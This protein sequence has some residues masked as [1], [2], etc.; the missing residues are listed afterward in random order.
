MTRINAS[1]SGAMLLAA[2]L[3]CSSAALLAASDFQSLGPS[4]ALGRS[5]CPQSSMP[6]PEAPALKAFLGGAPA[7]TQLAAAQ[8]PLHLK[9][10]V[11]RVQF[12]PDE[13]PQTTG[14]GTW[15]DIPFFTFDGTHSGTIVEDH[16]I[17]SRAKIYVQR[18]L[19]WASQYYQAVSR[20][21]VVLEVPD[22]LEDISAIYTLD[23]EM[24]E[25]GKDD[26]YSL[27]T[28]QLAVDAVKAADAEMDFSKYDMIM[29]FSAGCGQHTDFVPDSPDDI[30]P[31]SINRVLL[32]EILED[33]DPD[34]Q[35]IA[36]NDRKPD[37]SPFYVQFIQIFP[38]TAV[39][40]WDKEGNSQGALQGLLGVIVHEIGHYFGLPD[41]YDTMVGTRPTVG[42]YSLMATGFFNTVS[43]IPSH[44]DAWCKVFMGWEEPVTVNGSWNDIRIK[45]TELWG[46]GVRV[47]KVPISS[48][49]Y[50][51][52]E[53]RLRDE[54]FN[55]S[56]DF[57]ERGGNNFFP[58]VL[59]DDYQMDDGRYA[60]FDWSIPNTLGPNLPAMSSADS[61]RLGSGILIWHIDE[62]VLRRNFRDDLTLNF[63]NTEPQHL[64]IG[65]VEADGLN[66]MLE[67]FPAALD[68][69]FGSPFDVFG[70]AVPGVKNIDNDNL[71][72]DFGP[73]TNP[74]TVSHTGLPSNI[75]ISGFRSV[76][77]QPDAPVVDS[78]VALDVQ[79][80]AVT[81]GRHIPHTLSGWPR[82]LERLTA[83]S[84]PLVIDVDPR[85][86]GVDAV[87]VTDDGRVY[88]A[89][90]AGGG[91]FAAAA[92]DSVQG[93]PAAG[94]IDGDGS[95]DVVV[96]TSHGSVFAWRLASD[97]SMTLLPGW[98]VRLPGRISATPVLA[99]M[100]GNGA[101]EVLL[102]N[103]NGAAGSQLFVLT[104]DGGHLNG[105]PVIIED[106]AA[107][108]VAVLQDATLAPSAV[109]VGTLEGKLLAFDSQGREKYEASLGSPVI[110]AP[111][112]GRMGL[113]GSSEEQRVCVFTK[114]GK[115]WSLSAQT[116]EA[117]D[118]WPVITGGTCLSGGALGDVD[119]DGLNELV[120]PVDLTDSPERE[121][122]EL[123][124]LEY[125]GAN[126]A[127]HP[128]YIGMDYSYDAPYMSAPA[129]ADLD[130]DGGQEIIV[131]TRSRLVAAY[132]ADGTGRPWER[133]P[134]GSGALLPPVPADLDGDGKLDLLCA[135][136]EGY[137]Y[138]W[139]TGSSK[140]SPQWAGMGNGPSRTGLNSTVQKTQEQP[141][142]SAALSDNGC[143]VWPNPLR[144]ERARVVYRLGR[145]DV[146]RVTVK[147]F[148]PSGE[149]VAETEGGAAAAVG[150][151]NEVVLD[152][153][154]YASGIYI[155]L[156]E[157]QSEGAG[158]SRVMKKFA[159]IR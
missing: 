15:G 42:F 75:R 25:Y 83:G 130:G 156:I 10:G 101:L 43:R 20:G 149:T 142:G 38:E 135:D 108:P 159:V 86:S 118:G 44:P 9:I 11:V 97:G 121:G 57:D 131:S 21:K 48:T 120:V 79:F 129:L 46:E 24:A 145:A 106:E 55:N 89:L 52:L 132:K 91:G 110:A 81:G 154:R 58:D 103:R 68:P 104:G 153:S 82:N 41:L 95:P 39:Q 147:V 157:A 125:N 90:A 93:S 36:T 114:D 67:P 49:E 111:I 37:G 54:N 13:N 77:V 47:V 72:L 128:L 16:S 148:T 126:L 146:R 87:Q 51:L 112:A 62:E 35:G 30:H 94:D 151:D 100:D 115:I 50:Y 29:V 80:N 85:V 113:P 88:V 139:S 92:D 70:G 12:K 119:G 109:F 76:T 45:A 69:G 78:L 56:F 102:P 152:A 19:L 1:R 63:V 34:Y 73:Y 5:R 22:T 155:V 99:D 105:F 136:G 143:Y 33:G 137:L 66:H 124:V 23:K 122:V 107:A 127:G 64:G 158:T 96:A 14:N 71:N 61:A 4:A 40:D 7:G 27:R 74:S 17:D 53:N 150:L 123:H 31:V 116:G 3:L 26:D 59:V 84:S 140:L 134:T 8:W 18:N 144:G 28:S 65:L 32:S 98:P 141:A 138:A 117:A 60:E 6:N 133:Y 2:A